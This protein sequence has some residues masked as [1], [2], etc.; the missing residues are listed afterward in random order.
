VAIT[1]E[2]AAWTLGTRMRPHR[3]VQ[4]AEHHPDRCLPELGSYH[5][6]DALIEM[7]YFCRIAQNESRTV[8]IDTCFSQAGAAHASARCSF[9]PAT[10]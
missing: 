5:A 1:G 2:T 7:D 10:P 3:Q 6:P 4:D 8:V 9:P